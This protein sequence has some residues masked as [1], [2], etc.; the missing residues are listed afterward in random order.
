MAKK[1]PVQEK[2][3]KKTTFTKNGYTLTRLARFEI[4]ARVLRKKEY[5]F[6]READLSPVDFAMGWGPMSDQAV[7]NKLSISQDN[8]WYYWET[9]NLP[10]AKRKIETHS[11][12][13]HLIPADENVEDL[14][15]SVPEGK[16]V[17]LKGYLVN[18][19]A[20]DKWKWTSSL[21]RKDTG[22]NSCELFYVENYVPVSVK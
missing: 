12:N 14:L 13:M 22:S 17:H 10:I 20:D 3:A 11:G 7:I 5:W 6:G 9:S 19:K 4:K 2:L 15:L 16:V 21:S 8:R 18:A 1:D